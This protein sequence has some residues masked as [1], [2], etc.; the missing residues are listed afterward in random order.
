MWS[1]LITKCS[2]WLQSQDIHIYYVYT[3]YCVLV[4]K[5]DILYHVFDQV[6]DILCG[7]IVVNK[8]ILYVILRL[9]YN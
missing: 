4:D 9:S 6:S 5:R 2:S 1:Y 8:Y 3:I 7:I